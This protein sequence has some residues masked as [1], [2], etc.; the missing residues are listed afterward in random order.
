MA[1][2]E[3]QNLLKRAIN[4]DGE[5]F[6]ALVEGAYSMIYRTA[7]KWCGNQE[8][9]EDI[10]QEVCIK[11]GRAI[12]GFRMD[13][14]FSSWVYRITLNTVRDFQRG[15]KPH[16][17]MEAAGEVADSKAEKPEENIAHAE[18]WARVRQLPEKQRDAVLLVYAEELSHNEVAVIME[19]A[20]STVSWYIHEAKKQLKMMLD[21]DR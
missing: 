13:S 12:R 18:L 19:C 6:S 7:Y 8:D 17:P 16:L 9:A 11:L 20:E 15:R 5:A 4:G 1:H 3:E 2:A 14:A 21:D 10:A